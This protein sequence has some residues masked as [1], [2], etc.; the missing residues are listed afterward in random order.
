MCDNG[1]MLDEKVIRKQNALVAQYYWS[2]VVS[3]S[4]AGLAI[5]LAATITSKDNAIGPSLTW[6]G[7]LLLPATAIFRRFLKNSLKSRFFQ[8]YAQLVNGA[9]VDLTKTFHHALVGPVVRDSSH[10]LELRRAVTGTYKGY[11]TTLQDV[12]VTYEKDV[13]GKD[14]ATFA[15][16]HTIH[17]LQLPTAFPHLFI[18]SKQHGRKK[19]A[20]KSSLW[21]LATKLDQSQKLQDLEGDFGKY[22]SVYT[23]HQET[24]GVEFKKENDALRVLTPDVMLSLRDQ[25]FDF[26]YEIYED[27]L[28]VIHEPDL[29]TAAELENFITSLDAAL[30]EVLPQLIGH[31]FTNDGAKL[32]TRRAALTSDILF[33]PIAGVAK[34]VLAYLAL[35]FLGVLVGSILHT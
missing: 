8:G 7:I 30:S 29:L 18:A 10:N 12:R 6:I 11:S 24:E 14:G 31:N 27:Y 9:T 35:L 26:D 19:L 20:G 33:G 15:L 5:F 25:G 16:Q 1:P 23:T 13:P 3:R 22:F 28:Y 4:L 21:S 2:G 34:L 17:A 32:R